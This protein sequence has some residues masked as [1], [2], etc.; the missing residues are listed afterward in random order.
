M[1]KNKSGSI[2]KCILFVIV[3]IVLLPIFLTI[4]L[5]IDAGKKR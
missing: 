3:V 1:E 4:G 5:A 2:L